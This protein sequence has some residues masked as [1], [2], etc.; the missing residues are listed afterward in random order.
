MMDKLWIIAGLSGFTGIVY[1]FSMAAQPHKG[2]LK[3]V[4]RVAAGAVL[5]WLCNVVFSL[6]GLETTNSPL[7]ALA[8]GCWGIPGA[9]L[10]TAL[11]LWP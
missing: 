7:A 6:F 3:I 8:A 4:E 11:S 9:A 10:V 2:W 5:C 1:F